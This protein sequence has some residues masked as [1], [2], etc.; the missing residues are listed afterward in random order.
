MSV[1]CFLYRN[2]YTRYL[3]P[4]ECIV[5]DKGGE[6]VNNVM[7]GLTDSFKIDFRI[8]NPGNP[9]SNGIA[10]AGVKKIKNKFKALMSETGNFYF[11]FI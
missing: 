9:K 2:V 3:C 8:C 11:I 10:E 7:K 6:F 4:G 5:S 1:A